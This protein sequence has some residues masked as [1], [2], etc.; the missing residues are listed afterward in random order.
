MTTPRKAPAKRATPHKP[1]GVREPQ[2]HLKPAAQREAEGSEYVTVEWG[3]LAFEVL[4]DP[5]EWDFFTVSAPLS[6]GNI[7]LGLIGLLGN[8]Q[9]LTLRK[10][11]PKFTQGQAREL[12]DTI[13]EALGF[14]SGN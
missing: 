8:A 6:Q 10:M 7:G 5:D 3:G 4:A 9:V 14:G 13:S 11:Y 12:Y 1:A 2:D